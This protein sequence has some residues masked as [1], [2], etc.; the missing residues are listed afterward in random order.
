[1]ASSVA[2]SSV[3]G[4][5][6]EDFL[7]E[8]KLTASD[9][10][11]SDYFSRSVSISGDTV[12]VGVDQDD[13]NGNASG[14][15]YIF[16]RDA[17]GIW[18]ETAK[19]TASD[20]ASGDYF[21]YSVS[22]SGE[23]LV[24]GSQ[25]DDDNG[26]SSGSAYVFE[27]DEFGTWSETAKLTASDGAEAD[28]FGQI[29]SISGDT[30]VVGAFADSDNG[31]NSG[32]A[33]VFER[34]AKGTWSETAK[35]TASDG[36]ANDYF[37]HN[38]SISGETVVVGAFQDDDNGSG[39]G[40]AYVFD[41]DEFGT[42]SETAKLTASDGSA[43]DYFGFS[44]SI[45]G[46]IVVAGA[47]RDSGNDNSSGSA[48]VFDRDEFG[49]WSETAKLT[50]SDAAGGDYFGKSVSIS[51]ETVLI[52]A[53]YDNDN[54]AD[55][56]SAYVFERD[57]AGT[58]SETAKL[59]ASDGAANDYFGWK[60]SIS[61]ESMVVS[62]NFD[63]DNGSNSGSAY[64]FN[65]YSVLNLDYANKG[66]ASLDAALDEAF[67]ADR[68]A[69]RSSAFGIGG[70]LNTSSMPLT[71]IAV[72]PIEIG[73]GLMFLPAD[74]TNFLDSGDVGTAG[75]RLAGKFFAPSAGTLIFSD[76]D[77]IADGQFKQ[78][79]AA[80]LLN[81]TLTTSAGDAYML[82]EVFCEAVETGVS[83][84]NRVAGDTRVYA[85]Y[86]NA[87]T[88]I[89]Q[90]GILYIYGDLVNTG[91]LS[92]EY[93]NGFT[94]GE[95]PEPGDGFN[96]GGSYTIGQDATLSMP[97]PVWWL[98]VAGDLDI[99]ID[100]P[101]NFTMS[102]ATIALN[103]AKQ[104]LE[105]LSADL[106]AIEAGFDPS[107]FPIGTLRIGSDSTTQLV[108]N[109][110]NSLDAACEVLYVNELVRC[111][112]AESLLTNGCTIYARSVQRSMARLM[113]LHSIVIVEGAPA[114]P[115]D[116][117]GDGEVNGADL[118]L[119]IAFWGTSRRRPHRKTS[120]TN[121]ADLGLLI[122]AWGICSN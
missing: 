111:C 86:I 92:G 104:A 30:V 58:W 15:A 25:Y 3:M 9:G 1:M 106:G 90:E 109:H 99:A 84:V 71:F 60:V 105:T 49:T 79:D 73:A 101:A 38:V 85:D 96:I 70:I 103:G 52:G 120:I 14:S 4:Q 108:N 24:V 110:I 55:S 20:G 75:Y 83:G 62:A 77:V 50:A 36:S 32:S 115:A 118:G 87:G 12:V 45:S 46:E 43:I 82:G 19:L 56:G 113:I 114:C 89:I 51:G 102:E 66:Y 48:Y 93:N 97:D 13:D 76:L 10:V 88:T 95:A 22:I 41:R 53:D 119:M 37:G 21:G 29:V 98:R 42:W 122:A 67:P 63:D 31:T 65:N 16:E 59:T 34:D 35:L 18:S 39:S 40:S 68:L 64:V 100:D 57:G 74:G 107:N 8:Q 80:L 44:V 72:E 47:Y 27:R 28:N 78:N 6:L 81:N 69:V 112:R 91:T 117:T 121:G 94:G 54:S 17:K 116:L 7:T 11:A 23:R 61:G 33:Y 2:C 5:T 26:I